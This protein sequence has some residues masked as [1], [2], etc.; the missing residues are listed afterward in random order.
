YVVVPA[1]IRR[2][3]CR[4]EKRMTSDPKRDASNR[5]STSAIISI[6]QH[7]IPNGMGQTEFFLHQLIAASIF[8]VIRLSPK[9]CSNPISAHPSSK[10]KN[11]LLTE[12][13]QKLPF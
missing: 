9:A 8:V 1:T 5:G 2:S 4:G 10:Y 3:H 6:P 13:Q 12:L 7:D 11:T